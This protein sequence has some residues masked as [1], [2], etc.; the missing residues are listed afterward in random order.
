VPSGVPGPDAPSTGE[1]AVDLEGSGDDTEKPPGDSSSFPPDLAARRD[2]VQRTGPSNSQALIDALAPLTGYGLTP[3]Q[4]AQIGF[5]RFP[6]AGAASY[7]HD[8]WFPRFGPG[9]RL[10][11]G[12]DIFAAAGTPV[13]SPTEGTVRL[14]TGGLGGITVSVVEPNGTYYYLAHLAGRAPGLV[15]GAKVTTGQVVG[16]V[17]TSGNALGTPPHVHFEVHPNGGGPVDPKP[18]LDGFLADAL[19]GTTNLISAYAAAPSAVVDGAAASALLPLP[20][21][22]GPAGPTPG[23]GTA[24]APSSGSST[25]TLFWALLAGLAGLMVSR[26]RGGEVVVVARTPRAGSVQEHERPT[27]RSLYRKWV[28]P[29]ASAAERV[30]TLKAT[31]GPFAPGDTTGPSAVPPRHHPAPGPTS[32]QRIV[33]AGATASKARHLRP[34]DD[35]SVRA[36]EESLVVWAT[37]GFGRPVPTAVP[38]VVD[39][40]IG[41]RPLGPTHARAIRALCQGAEPIQPLVMPTGSDHIYLTSAAVAAL[42][43]SGIPT[44]VCCATPSEAARLER[45]GGFESLTGLPVLT[46]RQLFDQMQASGFRGVV[47]GTVII[48]AETMQV[49]VCDLARLAGYLAQSGGCM[50]LLIY[51]SESRVSGRFAAPELPAAERPHL[52]LPPST[53]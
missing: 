40:V 15:E 34:S 42:V 46:T 29:P 53:S 9:W 2:S 22:P 47:D 28:A 19:A 32:G 52:S 13:R 10:H 25:S 12:T 14:A 45:S 17:G 20:A 26:A 4:I 8:W 18:V 21:G 43:T 16:F 37:E 35:L 44:L 50:K 36:A 7:T 51:S 33:R 11:E 1:A 49:P 5:G 39:K 38:A 27:M 30:G 3:E 31:P 48:V 23:S 41:L 6:V 24:S